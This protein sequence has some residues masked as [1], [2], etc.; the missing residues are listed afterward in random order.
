MKKF[1]VRSLLVACILCFSQIVNSQSAKLPKGFGQNKGASLSFTENKGQVSDQNYK[2]RPDVLYSGSAN[3]LVFHLRTTGITYQLSRIDSWQEQE[4]PKTKQKRK[5]P[6]KNTICRVDIDWLSV[7]PNPS[8]KKGKELVGYNN[9]YLESCPNGALNVKSYQEIIYEEIYKGIDLKW[10]QKDGQLK[11]DYIV[12]AGSDHTQIQLE[13]KGATISLQKNGSLVLQ[14]PLGKIIEEA[15]IVYQNNKKLKAKWKIK[16]QILSFEIQNIDPFLPYIIDPLV[17]LR[18]W[19]TYYGDT[20][21]EQGFAC[22]TDALNNVYAGGAAFLSGTVIATTGSHQTVMNSGMDGFLVKFDANGVRQWGTFYGG[23]ANDVLYACAVDNAGNVSASGVTESTNGSVM[24]TAGAHQITFGGGPRDAFLVQ[25]NS[26][27]VR[28]WGTYYGGSGNDEGYGCTIDNL[29]NM[30]LCGET[31]SGTGTIIA[32]AGIQQSTFGGGNDAFLVKFSNAGVR[33]WGTYYGGAGAD[34][35]FSCSADATGKIAIAGDTQTNGGFSIASASGHQPSIASANSAFIAVLTSSTGLR[36]WG[37]YY[38]GFGGEVG[39]ACAFGGNAVFLVG[40]SNTT[41]GTAIATVGS[42]QPSHATGSSDDGFIVKFNGIGVRQWGTYFGGTAADFI[43][44]CAADAS[45]N[46]YCGGYTSSVNGISTPGSHQVN[47]GGGAPSFDGFFSKFDALGNL[48]FSTYYGGISSDQGYACA[49][50]NI[51]G[52]YLCGNTSSSTGTVIATPGS[53][54]SVYGGN[55]PKDL[56][57][58]KFYA[59]NAPVMPVDNTPVSNTSICSGNTT[60][61]IATGTGSISWYTSPS[62]SLVI[63]SG[64]VFITP[65]L[66]AGNYTYYASVTNTCSEGQRITIS[67]TVNPS[68]TVSII[69]NNMICDGQ[70]ITLSSNGASSYSWSTGANTFSI[71]DT[72]TITTT[73]SVVGTL[74]TG[75]SS[76]AILQVTVNPLP[77]INV[78]SGAICSGNAFTINPTGAN[79]YTISGGSAIVSPSITTNYSVTGTSS[80]GCLSNTISIAS[81]TV[82]ATPTVSAVSNTT[83][84]CEGQSATLTANGATTYTWSSGGNGP[85][86]SISPSVTTS[87]TVTGTDA[88]G[89][90][91]VAIITQS[92]SLCTGSEQLVL[93]ENESVK[94]YPNP[95]SGEF[96]IISTTEINLKLVNELGQVVKIIS[97]NNS[98]NKNVSITN[99]SAGIYFI[100]GNTNDHLIKQKIIVAR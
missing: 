84:I 88:N 95:N 40:Y 27:G 2:P 69:G 43:F 62:S 22:S 46:V 100:F 56:F 76:Q 52:L 66:T 50:D 81:L 3:G 6:D 91:N 19:G 75:C 29:N 89:C 96:S 70:N 99:L 74:T 32:T 65:T 98:N 23:N 77:V 17:A 68:P 21:D 59:C 26:A 37:T 15:P 97:L 13:I 12:S 31:N 42:Y 85:N 51:G 30:F 28:Q 78:N 20:A 33:V 71:V 5:S 82:N 61:L 35:A 49:I 60:T 4:D 58:V 63:G 41:S 11:Y 54:Q 80:A 39:T 67:I 94:I 90:Q 45:S 53:H 10:Y 48:Q 92:V 86:I 73:Y 44:A 14:T 18:Q 57:L 55:G 79:T 34:R 36:Q 16:D 72:P 87:Y 24:T 8:T 38:G 9:Y 7:N 64:S 1:I 25:F 93:G 83:I 47:Y